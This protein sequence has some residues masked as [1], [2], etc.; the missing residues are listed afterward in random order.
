MHGMQARALELA[1]CCIHHNGNNQTRLERRHSLIIPCYSLFPQTRYNRSID[2]KA[3]R[4]GLLRGIDS[5]LSD[6][7]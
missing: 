6:K 5:Q 1:T 3:S 4:D 2:W 7:K